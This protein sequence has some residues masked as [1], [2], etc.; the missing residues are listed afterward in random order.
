MACT[1]C[2]TSKISAN[3]FLNE[4][5]NTF[6][7]LIKYYDDTPTEKQIKIYND[8]R[9]DELKDIIYN[10]KN[11]WISKSCHK[12]QKLLNGIMRLELKLPRIS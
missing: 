8:Y 6:N 5:A 11:M 7:C 3:D 4:L 10:I 12:H 1:C 9:Q 2:S